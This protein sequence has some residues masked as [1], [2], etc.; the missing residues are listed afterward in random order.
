VL[1]G[2][3]YET[4]NA[5]A[6]KAQVVGFFRGELASPGAFLEQRTVDYIFYGPRERR[7]GPL[8]GEIKARQVY[9][10]DTP[11]DGGVVIYQVAGEK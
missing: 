3:P 8:P 9:S 7:L 1:Y 11:G 5:G 6:E 4:V 10:S 2:H